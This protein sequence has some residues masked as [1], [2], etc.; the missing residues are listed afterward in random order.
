MPLARRI[1]RLDAAKPVA[2]TVEDILAVGI[3]Y[4]AADCHPAPAQQIHDHAGPADRPAVLQ[5]CLLYTSPSPR[6]NR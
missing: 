1:E 4:V 2:K 6:D 3:E 5:T